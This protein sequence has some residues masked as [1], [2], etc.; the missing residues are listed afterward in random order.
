VP[1]DPT[2]TPSIPTWRGRSILRGLSG[3]LA[4]AL[5]AGCSQL[6]SSPSPST[7]AVTN[8]TTA[9]ATSPASTAASAS[10]SPVTAQP[11]FPLTVTDDEGTEVTVE[12]EPQRIISL[13]PANTETVFALGAGERLVGGTDADDY[14]AEAKALSDVATFQGVNIEQV[15]DLEPDLVLAAGNDFTAPADIDR[16]RDLGLPVVVLYPETVEEVYADIELIGTVIGAYPEAA[17]ITAQMEARIEAIA[18]VAQA[19]DEPRVFYEL[20]D[21]PEIYGP[22]E[23]SFIADLIELAGG[24]P[25]TTDQSFVFP[26]ER[27]VEADPQVIVL[28]DAN[29]GATPEGVAA[30]KGGWAQMTAVREGEV[31]P[32]DD[33]IVTRPGPRLAEGLAALALA[34]DPHLELPPA[35]DAAASPGA[36]AAP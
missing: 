23:D 13:S 33:I 5:L 28:G 10:A 17:A 3:L 16:L 15:V 24:G 7:S 6:G 4:A 27:L 8:P 12:V 25:I 36:S 29:Y 18:E 32:I 21:Q 31:R 9:V 20:G 22:A 26:L 34:I 35:D 19:G 2:S 11:A 14:P 1:H 30:R